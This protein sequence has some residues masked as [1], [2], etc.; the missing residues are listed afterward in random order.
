MQYIIVYFFSLLQRLFRVSLYCKF[1][2][3]YACQVLVDRA[4]ASRRNLIHL[5]KQ[6]LLN[7]V[8]LSSIVL[9]GEPRLCL[10]R[11]L[12]MSFR[13]AGLYH[14]VVVRHHRLGDDY[15]AAISY[16]LGFIA[17]S[18]FGGVYL[19]GTHDAF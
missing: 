6:S 2:S 9:T 17:R 15:W 5:A 16:R 18:K 11:F 8:L 3:V 19:V 7:F 13:L 10:K 4:C 1:I 12:S 14:F